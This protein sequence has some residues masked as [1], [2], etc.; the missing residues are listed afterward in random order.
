MVDLSV[1][2][3]IQEFEKEI[4]L[5]VGTYF[6]SLFFIF[7]FF[8]LSAQLYL[9]ESC[10]YICSS[11]AHNVWE[12]WDGDMISLGIRNKLLYVFALTCNHPAILRRFL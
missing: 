12:V 5:R 2:W 1:N 7:L 10:S 8:F 6:F 3:P 4:F 9:F 11:S